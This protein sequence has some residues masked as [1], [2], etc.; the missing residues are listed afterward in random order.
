MKKTLL[1]VALGLLASSAAQVMSMDKP[2]A[3]PHEKQLINQWIETNH[4][5][6]YGDPKD[7]VYPGGDPLFN[8]QT[9]EL[10]DR[11]CYIIKNHPNRPWES[12]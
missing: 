1:T 6:D 10:T 9:G 5:N 12:Q 3:T 11:Y 7:T 4:L 2:C 8:E